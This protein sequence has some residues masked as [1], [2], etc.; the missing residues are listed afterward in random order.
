MS[1]TQYLRA[2]WARKW[3]VL[4]LF[5]AVGAAGTIHAWIQPK[6]YV[7]EAMLVLDVRQDPLLGGFASA[8]SMATQIEILRSDKVASKVVRMLGFDKSAESIQAWQKATSGKIPLDRYYANVLQQGLVVESVHGSN[9][10]SISFTAPNASFAASAATAF[11]QAAIDVAVELRV[12]PARQSADWFDSQNK[13]LR[14]NLE[15]AQA[16][17]S[18]YQQDKGI[19]ATDEK[20]D[21]EVAR[22]DALEAELVTAQAERAEAQGRQRNSGNELSPDVQ[23]SGLAQS[24]KG[25]LSAAQTKLIEVNNILGSNHPQR[26]QLEAQIAGLKQQLAAEIARVSGSASVA[27]RVSTQKADELRALVDAQ[28]KQVLSLRSQRDQVSVLLR[29][30]ETAQRA[31]E[32]TSQRASQLNLESQTNQTN[33]RIL[34]P[35]VESLYPSKRKVWLNMVGSLVGGL[36][37]GAGL[38]IGLELLDRRIRGAEDMASA[39]HGV[40]LIGVLRPAGASQAKFRRVSSDTPLP[41]RRRLP[42]VE[43]PR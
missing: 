4:L 34:S 25:Q 19:V 43:A 12:E 22:L 24:L 11:A 26:L 1:I 33:V 17:L 16:R 28:K 2:V 13:V 7:A 35:A 18:K 10:I 32:G 21:R 39:D 29:D 41:G 30:V 37:I 23:Q 9:I 8:A 38:A 5:L 36:I 14:A 20:V 27:S 42:Y 31:Y 3:M 15:Q 6:Q 40:P